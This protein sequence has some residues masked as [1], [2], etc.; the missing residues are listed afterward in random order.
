MTIH[1]ALDPARAD[2]GFPDGRIAGINRTEQGLRDAGF[3]NP[4]Y[5][6]QRLVT[7]DE[8]DGA[9]WDGA[10]VPGWYYV[11]GAVVAA[12]AQTDT[13][14]FNA[15]LARFQAVYERADVDLQALLVWERTDRREVAGHTWV[16]DLLHGWMIPWTRR[17]VA[18]AAAYRALLAQAS[19]DPTALAAAKTA[20][21]EALH[22]PASGAREGFGYLREFET[23]GLHT[24]YGAADRSITVWRA[25][26]LLAGTLSYATD[27]AT[28]G[29]AAGSAFTVTYPDGQSVATWPMRAAVRALETV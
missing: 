18:A 22:G 23:L 11:A 13:E 4:P 12:L 7:I 16:E 3:D 29:Y 19:P 5:T 25:T 27:A 15:D 10:C 17:C 8:T 21:R 28:G 1:L 14:Q 9:V 24:W 20:W 6:G 26:A 2:H